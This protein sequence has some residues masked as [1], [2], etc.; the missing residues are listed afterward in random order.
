MT[1][2]ENKDVSCGLLR[3]HD[4]SANQSFPAC[5]PEDLDTV[6][7]IVLAVDFQCVLQLLAF[8]KVVD[9]NYLFQ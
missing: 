2:Q 1:D 7:E 4:A 3:A 8:G 5:R 9:Q 6:T